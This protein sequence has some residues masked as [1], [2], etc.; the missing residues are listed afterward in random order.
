MNPV[1]TEGEAGHLRQKGTNCMRR[2]A[3]LVPRT[4][5]KEGKGFCGPRGSGKPH[6]MHRF[7]L[8]F[9]PNFLNRV[10]QIPALTLLLKASRTLWEVLLGFTK[11]MPNHASVTEFG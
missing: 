5:D 10:G 4:N 8:E 3:F 2:R 11:G 1:E 9:I 6:S 7:S